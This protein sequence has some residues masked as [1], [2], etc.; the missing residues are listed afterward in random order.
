MAV[1][2]TADISDS[3]LDMCVASAVLDTLEVGL[4]LRGE[5][6]SDIVL[7]DAVHLHLYYSAAQDG[8]WL[9]LHRNLFQVVC[10]LLVLVSGRRAPRGGAKGGTGGRAGEGRGGARRKGRGGRRGEIQEGEGSK[11]G[12]GME[13]WEG[14]GKEVGDGRGSIIHG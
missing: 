12:E 2:E 11:R 9:T 13:R 1:L 4:S 10:V 14:E 8:K 7:E 6:P 5:G 3:E